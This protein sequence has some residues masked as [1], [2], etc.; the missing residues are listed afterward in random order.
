MPA[1]P[2]SPCIGLWSRQ[3][4]RCARR[5]VLALGAL[6]VLS[7]C[8]PPVATV[9]LE[10]DMRE[11]IAA[12]RF[13]PSVDALGVRGNRE[14]LSW[15]RSVYADTLGDG[16][17][18]AT[19]HFDRVPYAGQPV[20]YKLRV[21]RRGNGADDGWE[22]SGNHPLYLHV[23]Q[24]QVVRHFNASPQR[25][26]PQRTGHIEPLGLV[27]S[28]H[29]LPRPVQVW[30]PPAYRAD[31]QRRFPVLYLHDGQNVFDDEA[32]LA[33]WRVDETAQRLAGASAIDA[34][35]IVAV[36]SMS[37]RTWDYTPTSLQVQPAGG[38]VGPPHAVGG[39]APAYARFLIEELKPMIDARYRTQTGPA[40]TAVGG[41]SL[42]GLVSLWLA[43]Q[44]PHVFGAALA[45]SP[46]L[47]WDDFL[48]QRL[49][50]AQDLRA[51]Q[52]PLLWLDMGRLEGRRAVS[53][54]RRLNKALLARGWTAWT[55]AYHEDLLGSH[56]EAS[57]A[58]RVEGMLRFLYGRHGPPPIH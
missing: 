23:P 2:P 53:H 21:D 10:I 40:A 22:R 26:A 1:Q 14:P 50:M 41:S 30:L 15:S 54:A 20:Q 25:R 56:D 4:F 43:L 16:R 9:R 48:A 37:E 11:E 3:V 8:S 42:G 24:Q 5:R 44:H 34:P 47:W 13:N 39:G 28:V 46:T 49:V 51:G 18:T 38:P 55:L 19:L 31:P 32:S 7:A 35:I 57:W 27:P 36:H 17:Y 52:R 45:V 29:V 6:L 12:G 58:A 33:E